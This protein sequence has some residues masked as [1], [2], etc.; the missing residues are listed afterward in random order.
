MLKRR[1]LTERLKVNRSNGMPQG[2]D[3]VC[4]DHNHEMDLDEDESK[5]ATEEKP[6][7]TQKE[8]DTEGSEAVKR[9]KH[10]KSY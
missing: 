8:T 7:V 5:S 2:H 6:M 3:C 4:N 9:D 1:W 10:N